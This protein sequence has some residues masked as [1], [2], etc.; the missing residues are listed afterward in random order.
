[1]SAISPLAFIG[2]GVTLGEG[3]SIGPFATVLGPCT[4]GDG[5]WIGPG[6]H[7]GAPPEISSLPQNTAW[8]A[9]LQHAGV[10]IGD[11]T[12]IRE[13]AVIHQGSHR[14]TT[15]GSDCWILNRAYLAHDVVVGDAT[16]LSAGVSI[17]G[18]CTIGDHVNLGL[19]VSVHQRRFIASGAIVGMGTPV[20]A[21]I[22]PFAKVYGTPARVQG[23][24]N[25]GMSRQGLAEDV[26]VALY[27]HYVAR[28]TSLKV[29]DDSLS[30]I[31]QQ[32]LGWLRAE[33]AQP[34]QVNLH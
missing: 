16:T 18:H 9:D 26:S 17:G 30:E 6:A 29:A 20:T 27:N 8:N 3:V 2:E 5:V 13:G 4:I 14:A 31:E 11:R 7:I 15:V 23:I 33:P 32:V 21:D 19:N 28:G 22:P 34:M 24:N 1:M 25:V 12:V 10:V